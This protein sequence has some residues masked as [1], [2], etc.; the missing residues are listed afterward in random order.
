MKRASSSD[1]TRILLQLDQENPDTR[2][3]T[4]LLYE[5]VY[6][7]LR[8]MAAGFMRAQRKDHTLQPTA[9]VNE[10][11]V[12]LVN[13]S[14][15]GWQN[16]AHFFGVAAKAMRHILVNH[17]RDRAAAKRGGGWQRVTL[18]GSAVSES[19]KFLEVL[20]LDNALEKLAGN[21]ERM[22]RVVELRVFAGMTMRDVAHVLG[23]S[24]R[25]V[26]NDW[27]VAKLWLLDE[28]SEGPN[29]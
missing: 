17:A 8:R 18:D 28:M 3:A 21:D 5:A 10:A 25:T 7:E 22:A 16:S 15:V 19:R 13:R 26:D 11:Y 24:R 2:K 29:R 1:I 9:L 14:R 20:A 23:V 4:D 27:K 6:D 12:K